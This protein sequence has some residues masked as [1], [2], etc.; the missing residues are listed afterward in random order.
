MRSRTFHTRK[1]LELSKEL[2]KKDHINPFCYL[3][4]D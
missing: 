2:S 1:V 3:K 4:R